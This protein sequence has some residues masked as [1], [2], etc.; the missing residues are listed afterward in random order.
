MIEGI[1]IRI[2]EENRVRTPDEIPEEIHG[3]IP[4]KKVVEEFMWKSQKIAPRNPL[5]QSERVAIPLYSRNEKYDPQLPKKL[6]VSKNIYA[7]LKC[8]SLVKL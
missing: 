1:P 8:W 2:S 3:K 4:K 6:I 5:Q 7:L